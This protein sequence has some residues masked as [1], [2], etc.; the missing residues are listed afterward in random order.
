MELIKK[1]I[2]IILGVLLIII[3]IAGLALK[4]YLKS[5]EKNIKKEQTTSIKL[6]SKIKTNEKEKKEKVFV[7]IKGAIKKPGVYEIDDDKKIID[8]VTE[9]GGLTNEAD[10]TYINLAKKVK[11][12]MV[13]LIY[14]KDQIKEAKKKETFSIINEETC[15]CPVVKNDACINDTTNSNKTTSQSSKNSTNSKSNSSNNTSTDA[16]TKVNINTASLEELQTLTGIG[17]SKA[18]S[19]IEYR[20]ENGNY[21]S[22]EDIL[23]VS[24]IGESLYEKIKD[25]ITV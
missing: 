23:N 18:K 13:V 21:N 25:N 15:I 5:N 8:V 1:H 19:I 20:E 16:S 7:D 17:E 12:E 14:T 10:T 22:P 6:T 9:A 4:Y 2:K 3:F 11:N 24:G